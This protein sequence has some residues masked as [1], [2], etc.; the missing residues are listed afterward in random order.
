MTAGG[1]PPPILA[2]ASV[3]AEAWTGG[4]RAH[5]IRDKVRLL[6]AV[7]LDRPPKGLPSRAW[8]WRA[9]PWRACG[10]RGWGVPTGR[11]QCVLTNSFEESV[12]PACPARPSRTPHGGRP[13]KFLLRST[14][15]RGLPHGAR[16]R[17]GGWRIRRLTASRMELGASHPFGW[18]AA[19]AAGPW[20]TTIP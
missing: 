16:R 1:R 20:L 13:R 2:G 7:L 6:S 14:R 8:P 4:R 5:Q 12:P 17:T 19:P 9:W 18:G 3:S 11:A 10:L 15:S